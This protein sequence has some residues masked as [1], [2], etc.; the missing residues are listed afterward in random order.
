MSSKSSQSSSQSKSILS[1]QNIILASIAWGLIA[2][3]VFLFGSPIVPRPIWYTTSTYLLENLAFL[4]AGLLCFRN[5]RSSQIVSGRTVWLLIGL[6]MFF[7]FVA[8][9]LLWWWERSLGYAPEVSP[10]DVLFLSSYLLLGVGML[11]AVTSK[12]L[13][14]SVL[15]WSLIAGIAAVGVFVAYFVSGYAGGAAEEASVPMSEPTQGVAAVMWVNPAVAPSSSATDLEV[16]SVSNVSSNAIAQA[17]EVAD[18]VDPLADKPSWIVSLDNQLAAFSDIVWILYLAGDTFL[19]VMATTLLLAFWGGRFSVS[20]R[21][22]A[23]AGFSLYL[24]DIWYYYAVDNF[25]NYETGSLPEVFWIFSAV[26][27]CI[28]AAVEYNLSTR[29]RR[30]RRRA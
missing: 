17:P 20:W 22:I 3:F 28:G 11:M 29:S 10:A 9:L 26:L 2:L 14:L 16:W 7:Y 24:A 5:W 15:Q 6:G 30:S 27:F 23:A 8:N 18:E 1:V 4:C 25:E 12:Q 19:M 13:N 21:F